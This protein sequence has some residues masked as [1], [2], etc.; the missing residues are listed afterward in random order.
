[1][2]YL[3]LPNPR[4]ASPEQAIEALDWLETFFAVLDEDSTEAESVNAEIAELRHFGFAM[5]TPESFLARMKFALDPETADNR[6]HEERL[7]RLAEHVGAARAILI[8]S[9]EE[10]VW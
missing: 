6:R 5:F 7:E 10:A 4:A 9:A 3:N 1:M 2:S 8:T